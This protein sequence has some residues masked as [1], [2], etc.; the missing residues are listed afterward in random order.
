MSDP[1]PEQTDRPSDTTDRRPAMD[2]P[3]QGLDARL[4]VDAADVSDEASD[5]EPTKRDESPVD[6]LL[7]TGADAPDAADIEDPDR[8]L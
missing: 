3:G 7:R 8:Q 2:A 5:P 1:R 6:V 4:D